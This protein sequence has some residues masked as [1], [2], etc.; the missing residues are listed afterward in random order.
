MGTPVSPFAPAKSPSGYFSYI[1]SVAKQTAGLFKCHDNI[2][3]SSISSDKGEE[4][5]TFSKR[6]LEV[7]IHI[8]MTSC[9]N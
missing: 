7:F 9:V 2:L 3:A 6:V 4:L 1:S 8:I 5:L